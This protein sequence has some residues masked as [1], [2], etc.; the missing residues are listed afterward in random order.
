MA[1]N[2]YSL[3]EINECLVKANRDCQTWLAA[4][5]VDKYLEACLNVEALEQQRATIAKASRTK[6]L[7]THNEDLELL[8]VDVSSD[9]A[10][11]LS[12]FSIVYDGHRYYYYGQ[13]RY[14]NLQCAIDYVELQRAR[15][16][17]A[18]PEIT[19]PIPPKSNAPSSA[20]RDLMLSAGVSFAEG[21]YRFEEYRYDKLD[22][23][24]AYAALM[25]AL[26][27]AGKPV[28]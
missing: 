22:D 23:A 24:L 10:A 13:Y 18:T 19:L 2:E 15:G 28:Q 3:D 8:R 27:E 20:D 16:S 5:A 17:L 9:P 1:Q 4:R 12:A 25:S 26:R 21:I 11:R 7:G 14:D 6:A